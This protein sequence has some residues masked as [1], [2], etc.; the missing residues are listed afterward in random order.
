ML[1]MATIDSGLPSSGRH[2]Y[3]PRLV[4]GVSL[5]ELSDSYQ[6]DGHELTSQPAYT[7]QDDVLS[8]HS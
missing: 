1:N 6:F 4:N 5:G 2:A 3:S 7:Y 8:S